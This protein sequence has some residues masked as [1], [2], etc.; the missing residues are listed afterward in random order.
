M[1]YIGGFDSGE[2][3]VTPNTRDIEQQLFSRMD[4]C[5]IHAM[6]M[7]FPS[8][9]HVKLSVHDCIP[10]GKLATVGG[11]LLDFQVHFPDSELSKVELGV[12]R[13]SWRGNGAS[14]V[15]NITVGET[16]CRRAETDPP[17]N[18]PYLFVCKPAVRIEEDGMVWLDIQPQIN[19][20]TV[21][22]YGYSWST[23][24]YDLLR[25]FHEIKGAATIT[26]KPTSLVDGTHF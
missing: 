16:Q 14:I 11:D 6:L 7:A 19:D 13:S 12:D 5:D 3:S 17:S 24:Q 23:A 22:A 21:K 4:V 26:L 8:L 25:K 15:T 2:M 18:L 10:F 1:A 20:I 9:R